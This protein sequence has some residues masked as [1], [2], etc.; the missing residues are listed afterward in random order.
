MSERSEAGLRSTHPGELKAVSSSDRTFQDLLDG[1]SQTGGYEPLRTTDLSPASLKRQGQQSG[2]LSAKERPAPSGNKPSKERPNA[3][4]QTVEPGITILLPLITT[5]NSGQ[6]Q[7]IDR[8]SVSQTSV[9]QGSLDDR[10]AVL[11][12]LPGQDDRVTPGD[13]TG[14]CSEI[15]TSEQTQALDSGDITSNLPASPQTQREPSNPPRQG[16]DDPPCLAAVD[17]SGGADRVQQNSSDTSAHE[18]P[19]IT[20]DSG[21][22]S[23]SKNGRSTAVQSA[24]SKEQG[25]SVSTEAWRAERA[26]EMPRS[27]IPSHLQKARAK[28][29]GDSGP[30]QVPNSSSSQPATKNS[31]SGTSS[32]DHEQPIQLASAG[33]PSGRHNVAGPISAELS[34]SLSDNQDLGSEKQ[35]LNTAAV[36]LDTTAYPG[37]SPS[38]ANDDFSDRVIASDE[39][40]AAA[41]KSVSRAEVGTVA[42]GTPGMAGHAWITSE[43]A[44]SLSANQASGSRVAA[45]P[46]LK[47]PATAIRTGAE[48]DISLMT[49]ARLTQ[50]IKGSQI[51]V[52]L[53]TEDLGR[54]SVHAGYSRDTLSAQISVEDARLGAMVSSH[55]AATEQKLYGEH[56]LRSVI[57][58]TNTAHTEGSTNAQSGAERQKEND[59]RGNAT[60]LTVAQQGRVA[61]VRDASSTTVMAASQVTSNRLD[62]RI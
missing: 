32:E 41:T 25:A 10:T 56:G 37:P 42:A 35:L 7:A 34:I 13:E 61:S 16:A 5:V 55:L 1:K 43:T 18:E 30:E 3:P 31:G 2:A 46:A 40:A 14:V 38:Q 28:V 23:P 15:T 36:R 44:P 57:T 20:L 59:A 50:S 58:M 45:D 6:V 29:V 51:Q 62:I 9:Q 33:V 24:L 4:T 22:F 17:S 53:S 12:A 39:P 52:N 8:S 27:S 47:E 60:K 48:T 19:Q 54:I 26:V 11:T 21:V 49:H